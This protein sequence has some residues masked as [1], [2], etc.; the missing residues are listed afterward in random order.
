MADT[1]CHAT[2]GGLL[3]LAPFLGLLKKKL[4]LWILVGVGAFFGALPDA[5]G[6]W[7]TFIQHD[8]WRLYGSAHS[9]AIA[10]VLQYVPMYG[11]HLAVDSVTHDP[12]K[13]WWFWNERLWMDLLLWMVN[14]LLIFLYVKVWRWNMDRRH[15]ALQPRNQEF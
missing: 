14:L 1:V 5:L 8:H 11:L 13:R 12:G 3:L 9:G 2:Q 15:P 4:W 10:H 7:G 6:V